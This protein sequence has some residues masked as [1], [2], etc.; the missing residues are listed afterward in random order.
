MIH[1][2]FFK[3]MKMQEC[4][5][6]WPYSLTWINWILTR[7]GCVLYLSLKMWPNFSHLLQYMPL[8]ILLQVP[9]Y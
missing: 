3:K 7:S 6:F 5:T 8:I 4:P 9:P 1:E 2:I